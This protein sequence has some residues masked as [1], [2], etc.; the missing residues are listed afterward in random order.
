MRLPGCSGWVMLSLALWL[1]TPAVCLNSL[2][3]YCLETLLIASTW[4]FYTPAPAS[5]TL[6]V[7]C[8]AICCVYLAEHLFPGKTSPTEDEQVSTQPFFHVR[9][10]QKDENIY[11]RSDLNQRIT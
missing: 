6:T 5:A 7:T 8:A 9:R 4:L 11:R 1:F 10:S 2:L 3:A